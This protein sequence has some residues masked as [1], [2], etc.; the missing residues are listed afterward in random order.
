MSVTHS[1]KFPVPLAVIYNPETQRWKPN[2]A[3]EAGDR[4]H[5]F[6]PDDGTGKLMS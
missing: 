3:F 1:P 4:K 5:D 2:A 6:D